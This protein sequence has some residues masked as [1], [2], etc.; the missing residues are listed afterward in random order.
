MYP[1]RFFTLDTEPLFHLCTE[2]SLVAGDYRDN[3]LDVFPDL[4]FQHNGADIVPTALVLVC[5]MGGTN[6]EV[7][8]L[9]K[10]A[11]GRVVQLLFAVIAE[12]ET[13]EHIA[14]A[15]CRSAMALLPDFLHLMYTLRF[16]YLANSAWRY[17][18]VRFLVGEHPKP[19]N[20]FREI[21]YALQVLILK[22]KLLSHY[23]FV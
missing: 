13:G 5:P 8:P 10:V 14:L 7:L 2:V 18:F 21:G 17:Q 3:L 6:K 1:Y 9:F 20:C 16:S 12:H 19:L 11:C 22:I 4:L 15:R 23:N